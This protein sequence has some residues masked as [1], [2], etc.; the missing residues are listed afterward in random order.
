MTPTSGVSLGTVIARPARTSP[1]KAHTRRGFLFQPRFSRVVP[2]MLRIVLIFAGGGC[3]SVLR[4]LMQGW[5][6]RFSGASFPLG[7][8]LVNISGCFLIG[9]LGGLFFGPRPINPD[10]RFAILTGI[11]GGYTT[12]STFGWETWQLGNE[13]QYLFAALN[14]VLSVAIGLFAVWLGKQLAQIIYG[15]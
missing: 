12:F 11:L 13:R 5:L 3:G 6:Q 2:F 9:F 14:V 1:A 7:T 10:Y 8:L 15:T 4:Y